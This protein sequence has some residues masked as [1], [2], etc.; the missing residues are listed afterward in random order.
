MPTA[1]VFRCAASRNKQR[2]IA[3]GRGGH[4]YRASSL[5]GRRAPGS[6]D[7]ISG[8]PARIGYNGYSYSSTVNGIKCLFLWLDSQDL[9]PSGL[10]SRALGLQ[11]RCLSE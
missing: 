1:S 2:R 10:H 8:N 11:L 5:A 7:Y 4:G 3:W 9:N 6:R